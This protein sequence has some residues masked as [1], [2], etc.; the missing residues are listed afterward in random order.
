[1][2]VK[3]GPYHLLDSY[4]RKYFKF[5]SEDDE[6]TNLIKRLSVSR[7]RG[8][9]TRDELVEVCYWKSPRVL[10]HIKSNMPNQIKQQ[11][12]RVFETRSER[13][14]LECLTSLKGVGVPMASAIL[15][16]TN[17]KRYPVIDIRVWTLLYTIGIVN[18]NARGSN[19]SFDEWYQFLMIVRHFGAKYKVGAR[20][21]ENILFEIHRKYQDGN[22]YR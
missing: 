19:F 10:R 6:T 22:L 13:I 17:P 21:I 1:M 3:K 5:R 9:L 12:K 2:R 8:F 4:I 7:K 18:S 11:T 15:M 14:K 20:A 16:L